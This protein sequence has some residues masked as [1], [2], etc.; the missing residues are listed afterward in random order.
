MKYI[1]LFE[2]HNIFLDGLD[3]KEFFNRNESTL[4]ELIEETKHV[5]QELEDNGFEVFLSIDES[6]NLFTTFYYPNRKMIT[7][8]EV[9]GKN[10]MTH[11]SLNVRITL[12][13]ETPE[14][15]SHGG[16]TEEFNIS[17]IID[18]ILF[19]TPYLAEKG[20]E[21]YYFKC[22]EYSEGDNLDTY[23]RSINS[24][25]NSPLGESKLPKDM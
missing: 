13:G 4:L 23:Y 14:D 15:S 17:E 7:F 18:T 9:K 21:L 2:D 3:A 12:P 19:A 8:D 22:S 25:T 6:P 1:K 10:M 11:P 5:F 20:L 16:W 24:V